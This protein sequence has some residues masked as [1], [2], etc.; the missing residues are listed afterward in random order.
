M[1]IVMRVVTEMF[2]TNLG[3]EFYIMFQNPACVAME[4][5]E[6]LGNCCSYESRIG[7]VGH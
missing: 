1:V 7:R 5:V 2:R 3:V 6:D 4:E